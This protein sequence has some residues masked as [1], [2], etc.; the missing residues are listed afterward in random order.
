M[1]VRIQYN[2]IDGDNHYFVREF[3]ADSDFYIPNDIPANFPLDHKISFT[4][5]IPSLHDLKPIN[6]EVLVSTK[7]TIP[8]IEPGYWYGF[9]SMFA[10]RTPKYCLGGDDEDE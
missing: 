2:D 6:F 1:R 9:D 7:S 10:C 8:H 4:I 3:E 5:S